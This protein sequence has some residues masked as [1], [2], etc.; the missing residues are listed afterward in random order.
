MRTRLIAALRAAADEVENNPLAYEWTDR[1]RCNC[2]IVARH[3]LE[4][5]AHT[6]QRLM[7]GITGTWSAVHEKCRS[8]GLP[9]PEVIHKLTSAGFQER[10]FREL[11]RSGNA[12]V[13]DA[14]EVP[15][16]CRASG[17]EH[18]LPW[19]DDYDKPTGFI[20][21]ARKWADLMESGV[22]E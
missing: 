19:W 15:T 8:S 13:L 2:G 10:E 17:D 4:V 18:K 11:E 5:E 3:L 20:A 16:H 21:Y 22:L 6:M 7:S 9:I 12:Y 14:L 1:D